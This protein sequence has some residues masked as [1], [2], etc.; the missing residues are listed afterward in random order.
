MKTKKLKL[1]GEINEIDIT[2][3]QEK[4]KLLMN[5][6]EAFALDDNILQVMK[7][8]KDSIMQSSKKIDLFYCLVQ[9]SSTWKQYF[10]VI[11]ESYLYF[12]ETETQKIPSM[13]YYLGNSILTIKSAEEGLFVLSVTNNIIYKLLVK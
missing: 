11:S 9:Q 13:S 6:G 8:D 1:K 7:I 12:Y 2:A 3:N 4:M 10:V 5:I